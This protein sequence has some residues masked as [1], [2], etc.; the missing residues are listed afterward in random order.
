M[1]W[2]ESGWFTHDPIFSGSMSEK[3]VRSVPPVV[4]D[5]GSTIVH[6]C[7]LLMRRLFSFADLLLLTISVM[8]HTRCRANYFVSEKSKKGKK[9]EKRKAR[10]LAL[11]AGIRIVSLAG[12]DYPSS[13]RECVPD[14][15]PL[16]KYTSALEPKSQ[17]KRPV[18]DD[19]PVSRVKRMHPESA[20]GSRLDDAVHELIQCAVRSVQRL[21][22]DFLVDEA[23]HSRSVLFSCHTEAATMVSFRLFTYFVNCRIFYLLFFLTWTFTPVVTL[24]RS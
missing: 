3:T 24:G 10:K 18:E 8:T 13:P 9:K 2:V 19:E 5:D 23:G 16:S 12:C 21:S 4:G 20:R 22:V 1:N 17:A 14:V 6:A 7:I 15:H 11:Q